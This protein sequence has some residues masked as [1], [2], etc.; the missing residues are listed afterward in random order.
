MG[1]QPPPDTE[2]YRELQDDLKGALDLLSNTDLLARLPDGG[3]RIRSNV[4]RLQGRLRVADEAAARRAQAGGAAAA[5][6]AQPPLTIRS[7]VPS[8]QPA[9]S[10]VEGHEA[11]TRHDA[12]A[13]ET[14][15][16]STAP[17]RSG[18]TDGDAAASASTAAAEAERRR[19]Q[20]RDR[21]VRREPSVP[22]EEK[23]AQAEEV[24]LPW[25]VTRSNVADNRGPMLVQIELVARSGDTAQVARLTAALDT[26]SEAALPVADPYAL[27]SSLSLPSTP[28]PPSPIICTLRVSQAALMMRN[29]HV[30]PKPSLEAKAERY[31]RQLQQS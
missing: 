21:H 11:P 12:A 27:S 9:S 8:V 24:L 31:V 4:E 2:D 25:D 13:A 10:T 14:A 1:S 29:L 3:K 15:V 6:A 23:L 5:A 19:A 28:S 7:S 22:S 26:L 16:A 20:Q 30:V 17:P 18:E